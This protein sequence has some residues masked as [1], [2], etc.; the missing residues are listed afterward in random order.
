MAEWEE[1]ALAIIATEAATVAGIEHVVERTVNRHDH[2]AT[3]GLT[4]AEWVPDEYEMAGSVAE[5]TLAH[6]EFL[7]AHLVKSAEPEKGLKMHREAAKSLRM[8]LYEPGGVQVSLGALVHE[9]NGR[10]ER[11]QRM[12]VTSQQFDGNQID[13]EFIYL[14]VTE[15]RVDTETTITALY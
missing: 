4:I 1:E 10:R 14:S 7:L 9:E 2:H 5:P 11:F 13:G 6:Y 15:L 3:L 12:Y 8:M